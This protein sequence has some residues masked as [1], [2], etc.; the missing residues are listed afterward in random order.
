MMCGF[1][2]KPRNDARCEEYVS[3]WRIYCVNSNSQ[4]V[5]PIRAVYRE[6]EQTFHE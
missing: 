6:H 5:K 1:E 3:Q 4:S 2:S